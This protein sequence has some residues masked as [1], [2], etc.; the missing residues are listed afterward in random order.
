[1]MDRACTPDVPMQQ[2][3]NYDAGANTDDGSCIFLG[4]HGRDRLQLQ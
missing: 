1:M 4:L 2:A 3:S